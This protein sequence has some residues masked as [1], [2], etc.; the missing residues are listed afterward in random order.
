MKRL[1]FEVPP[2][3]FRDTHAAAGCYE[4]EASELEAS[5]SMPNVRN[6]ARREADVGA[7][8]A[9]LV[10]QRARENLLRAQCMP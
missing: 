5:A 10:R 7:M 8:A 2:F 1:E 4:A 3:A 9:E 6:K